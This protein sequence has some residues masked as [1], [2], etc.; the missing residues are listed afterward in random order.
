[1]WKTLAGGRARLFEGD[2]RDMLDEIPANSVDLALMDPP[3]VLE[4]VVK[5]F[6]KAGSKAAKHGTDGLYKRSSEGFVGAEWDTGEVVFDP[7]FWKSVH[8]VLKPGA[9]CLAMGGTVT[10]HK[11]ATA[12]VEGGL[13]VRDMFLW[14]YGSGTPKSHPQ[15]EDRHTAV[16]PAVEPI[17][18]ARKNVEG[19]IAANLAK[20]GTGV[21]FLEGQRVL[22]SGTDPE[23]GAFPA[24]VQHDGSD[25]I[26]EVFLGKERYFY[27]A[28]P[29]RTDRMEGT[30]HLVPP[31]GVEKT[32]W[33]PTVKPEGLLRHYARL[34][35][36]PGGVILDPFMGSG[37]TGKAAM[38]EGF[39]FIGAEMDPT[40]MPIA[41][42]RIAFA[43]DKTSF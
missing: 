21:F 30:D 38:L 19:T 10:Y 26:R 40:Y 2:C 1:M 25:A 15:G 28:K 20:W 32:N 11:L 34:C 27:C 33:H 9:Y 43:A 3:Y 37:S 31:E 12:M 6:G 41:E 8:R 39:Q 35:C 4:S 29:S 24:N 17:A 13:P 22:G 7:S 16:K 42:A 23:V 14:L 18:V 36:P 5:R